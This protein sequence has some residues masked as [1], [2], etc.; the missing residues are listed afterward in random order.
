[1]MYEVE[2]EKDM[3]TH[4]EAGFPWGWFRDCWY[5]AYLTGLRR[6]PGLGFAR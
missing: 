3:L 2:S 5:A 6:V 4:M 1:M